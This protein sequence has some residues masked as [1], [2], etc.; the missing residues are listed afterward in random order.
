MQR[1][2][3][4]H[5]QGHQGLLAGADYEAP[6]DDLERTVF[7][8]SHELAE[9]RA[10]LPQEESAS[11]DRLFYQ[12][13]EPALAEPAPPPTGDSAQVHDDRWASPVETD[14]VVEIGCEAAPGSEGGPEAGLPYFDDDLDDQEPTLVMDTNAAELLM[15]DYARRRAGPPPDPVAV[16]LGFVP[17]PGTPFPS[18]VEGHGPDGSVAESL[19]K[20]PP[21]MPGRG[22]MDEDRAVRPPV[23]APSVEIR[24]LE[25]EALVGHRL[26]PYMIERV[27]ARGSRSTVYLATSSARKEPVALKVL[28]GDAR[29][30]GRY[31]SER[32]P[33]LLRAARIYSKHVVGLVDVGVVSDRYFVAM[34]YVR[35][36]TLQERLDAEDRLSRAEALRVVRHVCRALEV[37]GREGLVHG[38]I[39]ADNIYLSV[40]GPI[41]LAGFGLA[42]EVTV[43]P[44]GSSGPTRLIGTPGY[45]A[46]EQLRGEKPGHR[47]DLYAIGVCLYQM[48]TGRMPFDGDDHLRMARTLKDAPPDVR[49]FAPNLE[50]PL[51]V[52]VDRLL[53]KTK[54]ERY[55]HA[56]E[57][58]RA[59]VAA[60]SSFAAVDGQQ[61]P[62]PDEVST[63]LL[64]RQ[65]AL[66]SA[67]Y[68]VGAMA[69]FVLLGS[70]GLG[71]HLASSDAYG[72][73]FVGA[74]GLL[75]AL[76]LLVVLDLIRRGQL[77]LPMSSAWLVRV[78]DIVGAVSATLLV[79]GVA[80]LPP[81]ILNIAVSSVAV[82]VLASWIYGILLRR[83]IAGARADGG[84]GR[85]LAV[86]GDTRLADW[87]HLHIP[88]HGA[89]TLLAVTRWA[90]LAYFSAGT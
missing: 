58:Q 34:E 44:S 47:S 88:L 87:H 64:V 43:P 48:L 81:A 30:N 63:P 4:L 54:K 32:G 20:A 46:P 52:I 73:A 8:L 68:V 59:A 71:P 5:A 85:M 83:G 27:V 7:Q 56:R 80:I 39:R 78:R 79:G 55:A 72:L 84:V 70:T 90:L 36:F 75:G 76:T 10:R 67:V 65:M 62:V 2:A 40:D 49:V 89:L 41:R 11:E 1:A 6:E 22:R 77:P 21:P 25:G 17:A 38:D 29:A 33:A 31:I 24:S 18:P 16:E 23:P 51:A 61:E 45:M 82:F 86:L 66:W 28:E 12:S 37:A 57:L 69:I 3:H 74:G 19:A 35:G 53:K 9:V 26:G 13:L 15:N 42:R 14:D 50:E 60:R